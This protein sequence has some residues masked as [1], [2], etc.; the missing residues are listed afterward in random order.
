[1]RETLG[2]VA[3]PSAGRPWLANAKH[4]RPERHARACGLGMPHSRRACGLGVARS[5]VQATALLAQQC[6]TVTHPTLHAPG[7]RGR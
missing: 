4:M 7:P 1:M 3:W 6:H 2:C 5:V